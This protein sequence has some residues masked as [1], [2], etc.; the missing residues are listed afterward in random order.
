MITWPNGAVQPGLVSLGTGTP[1]SSVICGDAATCTVTVFSGGYTF[2]ELPVS[3][4][5][6]VA[7]TLANNGVTY[8][9]ADGVDIVGTFPVTVSPA[10]LT[11]KTF[12]VTPAKSSPTVK[13]AATFSDADP[14]GVAADYTIKVMWGDGTS[15]TIAATAASKDFSVSATHHYKRAGKDI[16]TIT[17][18]DT[19]GATVSGSRTI[20]VR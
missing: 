6:S 7:I 9:P 10:P 18:T 20:T 17:I 19:G 5:G 11:L 14:L 13:L 16:V 4:A 15:S 1:A 8:T 12:A 3:G 2:P